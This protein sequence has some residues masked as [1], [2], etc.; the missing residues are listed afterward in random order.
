MKNAISPEI[1]SQPEKFK[2]RRN[3]LSHVCWLVREVPSSEVCHLLFTP[4]PALASET[5]AALS[6][7]LYPQPFRCTWGS[8]GGPK[9]LQAWPADQERCHP[10]GTCWKTNPQAA[11]DLPTPERGGDHVS[12]RFT[13]V[14]TCAEVCNAARGPHWATHA[15]TDSKT[16]GICSPWWVSFLT[17]HL[18][19][20][21][22]ATDGEVKNSIGYGGWGWNRILNKSRTP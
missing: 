20:W 18:E 6:A 12:T 15:N 13:V 14:Y 9:N 7:H 17:L 4:A 5:P 1:Y 10:L 21:G 8:P 22:K 19:F 16:V 2:H 3:V 11:P